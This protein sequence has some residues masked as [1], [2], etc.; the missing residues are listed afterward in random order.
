MQSRDH[1]ASFC[2]KCPQSATEDVLGIT[3]V[4]GALVWSH[5]CVLVNHH[6]Q[7]QAVMRVDHESKASWSTRTIWRMHKQHLE[8]EVYFLA[9]CRLWQDCSQTVT[10][11]GTV[12]R[13]LSSWYCWFNVLFSDPTWSI[14]WQSVMTTWLS[15]LWARLIILSPLG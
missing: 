14:H 4:L 6:L 15:I 12:P 2:I 1:L 7:T 10:K 3:M 8:R 9:I 5:V 13:P 11:C